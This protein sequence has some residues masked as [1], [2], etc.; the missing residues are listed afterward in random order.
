MSLDP[1]DDRPA[2]VQIADRLRKAIAGGQYG[3]GD[4]LPSGAALAETYGVAKQTVTNAL[5]TLQAEGL[6]VTRAGYGTYVR[7]HPTDPTPPSPEYVEI[8]KHLDSLD[9][10]MRQMAERLKV[11]EQIVHSAQNGAEQS[12][13]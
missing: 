10:N 11:V 3:P 8:T 4:K 5:K 2:S 7:T 6:L 9:E 12:A 13:Q 1:D